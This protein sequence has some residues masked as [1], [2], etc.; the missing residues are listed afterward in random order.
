MRRNLKYDILSAVEELGFTVDNAEHIYSR[1]YFNRYQIKYPNTES[2][3]YI[4]PCL[5]VETATF[6]KH[7]LLK[8]KR[9]IHIFIAS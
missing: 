3:S 7:I 2:V 8:S 9:R 1:T 5:Y 4:K 6:M